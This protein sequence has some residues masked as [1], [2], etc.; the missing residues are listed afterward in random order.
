MAYNQEKSLK[1]KANS[2][3][4]HVLNLANKDYKLIIVNMFEEWKE[5]MIGS[6]G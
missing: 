3:M 4:A 1:K 5:N 6:L 2:K